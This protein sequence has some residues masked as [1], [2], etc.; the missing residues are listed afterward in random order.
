MKQVN[1]LQSY[2]RQYADSFR[3]AILFFFFFISFF[4]L[5][6]GNVSATA[7]TASA[8]GNW[9]NPA[10][11][12]GSGTPG[13]SDTATIGAG[14]TV[15]VTANVTVSSL[16]LPT[17]SGGNSKVSINSGVTLTVS[18]AV[19]IPRRTGKASNTVAVGSGTL[20][21]GSVA[22]TLSDN[23]RKNLLTI[24]KGTATVIGDITTDGVNK[25]GASVNFTDKGTLNVGGAF[26]TG[27]GTV[28]TKTGSTINYNGSGAQTVKSIA[29]LGNLV[30]SGSGSKSMAAGIVITGNLSIAPGGSS[31]AKAS[32]S[33]T[34]SRAGTLTLA[35]VIQPSGTYGSTTSTAGNKSDTYFAGTGLI[36][37]SSGVADTTH[38][39]ILSVTSSVGNGS[40][41]KDQ[42]INIIVNFSEIVSSTGSVTVNLD[43][44]GTC[45]FSVSLSSTGT[46]NYTVGVGEN[47]SDLNVSSIS[48][49]IADPSGNTMTNFTPATNLAANKAI[50]IDTT[51]PTIS[52]VTSTVANG[53][54]KAGSLIPIRAVFSETVSVTGTPQITLGTGG[55]GRVVNYSTGSGSNTLTFNYT[56]QSGDT[57]SDL[58]TTAI[59]GTFTDA[60]GNVLTNFSP[61]TNLAANKDIVIDT[62]APHVVNVT[63]TNA[64]ANYK[65]GDTIHVQVVFSESVTVSN[66]PHLT[67]LTG[68]P[69]TKAINYTSGSGTATLV[70]DYL[71]GNK[72]F[73]SDLEYASSGSLSASG[74]TTI[75]DAA[76]NA[77]STTLPAPGSGTIGAGSLGV[78]KDITIDATAPTVAITSTSLT[79]TNVPIPVTAKFSEPVIGFTADDVTISNGSVGSFVAV[80]SSTY[81]FSVTPSLQGSVSISILSA[82][83]T[84]IAGN[85]NIASNTLTR[86]YDN[87]A[88]TL[89]LTTTAAGQT[90]ATPLSFTATFS[91]TVTGFVLSDISV[92]GASLGNFQAVSGTVYTFSVSP[93]SNPDILQNTDV[94]ISVDSNKAQDSAGNGNTASNSGS[95]IHIIFDNHNP[96]VALTSG[97]TEYTNASPI[98]MTATFSEPVNGFDISDITVA[99]GTKDNFH[100]NS[101]SAYTFDVAPSSQGVMTV[102]IA[103]GVAQDDASLLNLVSNI[104]STTY[105][106]GPPSVVLS[107]SETSPTN[108]S[109]F[110][111]TATFS[112]D[113]TGFQSSDLS[114]T[115]ATVDNFSGL[116]TT[117]TFDMTPSGGPISISIA[118]GAA[119]DAAGNNN[120]VSNTLSFVY[121]IT[122]PVI[123]EVTPVPALGVDPTPNYTF[124]TTE[125]GAITYGGS[126]GSAT[127]DASSSNNNTITFNEL[128][129]G[130]YDDCSIVVTDAAGNDSL[131]LIVNTFSIS[132]DNPI[133]SEYSPSNNA[134]GV[135][136]TSDLVLTFNKTVVVGTG[137]ITIKTG[138]TV[139]ET[140]AVTSGQVTGSNTNIITI[141]PSVTL[142]NQTPYYV[143][144]DATAFLD[145]FGNSYAGISTSDTWSFTSAD[146][147]AP[148]VSILSPANNATAAPVQ[149]NLV[150]T[151]SENVIVQSGFIT[152]REVDNSIVEDID[153]TGGQVT[154]SG[155]NV[156]NVAPTV[157]LAGSTNYYITVSPTAFAD[158]AGNNYAGIGDSSTWA[159]Q[160]LD[161]TNPFVTA[162]SPIDFATGVGASN[163]LG[164]T[165]NE[166]VFVQSG[167]AISIKNGASTFE[168]ITL[169]DARV[170]GSGTGTITINPTGTL[171]NQTVYYVNVSP[172]ALYDDADNT[173]GNPYDGIAD[174]TT[175]TFTTADVTSPTLSAVSLVSNNTLAPTTLAK[176]GDR[177]TLSFTSSEAISSPAVTFTSGGAS[178]TNPVTISNTSLNNWVASY[179]TSS[180]DTA[181]AIAYSI[182]Y[183]DLAGNAGSPNPSVGGGIT[184]DKTAPTLSGVTLI[185]NN[186]SNT[187]AK[188][189]N[190]ITLSFTTS[191]TISTPSVIFTSGGAPIGGAVTITPSGNNWTATYVTRLSDTEGDVTYAI[192]N[193]H[194]NA[195]NSASPVTS[196]TGSVTFDK[197]APTIISASS[198]KGNGTYTSGESI[199]IIVSFSEAVTSTGNVT[200]TL[201]TGATDRTCTFSVASASSGSCNYTVQA[202]DSTNDLNVSS[203]SGTIADLAGNALTNFTPATNLATNKA[204]VIDTTVPDTTI[205]TIT[206]VTSTKANGSYTTNEVIDIIVS[207]SEAVT[208]TG[209]VTV[210]L[211]TGA[212]DRTCTFSVASASSGSCNYTVQAGDSTNDLNVSS[213][214]GTIADLAGNALTNFTPA[215]NLATNKAIVIDTTT[216]PEILITGIVV[217]GEGSAT[218]LS[219]DGGTLQMLAD[220]LPVDAT[221]TSVTWSVAP[222]TGTGSINGS[223]LL[224]ALTKGTVTVTATANDGSGISDD[225]IITISGQERS[226]A[227][228]TTS[229]H[230]SHHTIIPTITTQEQENPIIP[231]KQE[232]N[233]ILNKTSRCSSDM[234]LTQ[235]LKAGS[236]NGKYSSFTKGIV[237]EVKILQAHL[238]R[239]GFASGKVDGILGPIT[240]G[241]IK[242]MQIYLGTLPDGF[243]GPKTRNLI[244]NSCGAKVLS[245]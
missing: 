42:V 167:E 44:G 201:E 83:A 150:I 211:E 220:I 236:K 76:G 136:A 121:D 114:V 117:Y 110:S 57:S 14:K 20:V 153:V 87:I 12:G 196:G 233:P 152:I 91:E 15:N 170:T 22:F 224:T 65:T 215:T 120:T 39:T 73:T 116:G 245:E 164:M 138:S 174:S 193:F 206:N 219:A 41:K 237:K 140:I 35:N 25:T 119:Q 29:Y 18:G 190:L 28:T 13:S 24:S 128:P 222:G 135:T 213:I 171:A 123:A 31:T 101:R 205:P 89:T 191:E 96:S 61:G 203:I 165:F 212:T 216:T 157:T 200:V 60:A 100:S 97:V 189:G 105:D 129:N 102:S 179:V 238:N 86:S 147:V 79:L 204:I 142:A 53:S 228:E 225:I 77:T 109:L 30:L 88:P 202:G 99:N 10:T 239:L 240:D 107:T 36:T 158:A 5:K 122:A 21:A 175:W 108:A 184:F 62:L 168:S 210:T 115:N 227:S 183:H 43:T 63:S 78:N 163:N 144:V 126:C 59:S 34:T 231:D 185:S 111:V 197:T 51:L 58:T 198:N 156:I 173:I 84:D 80:S 182:N 94:N 17:G 124:S 92:S 242:R 134:T 176:A 226:S 103:A 49:T 54:Y 137:N 130:I 209:N 23:M 218:T 93:V 26:L 112:E 82:V 32:L 56:V 7:F 69:V 132:N 8:N 146:T 55:G 1:S 232:K 9:N 85:E 230:H 68:S 229:V 166:N 221:N 151:F 98:S 235:N 133:V 81:T 11:W 64:N 234:I 172:D 95:P 46:C 149:S 186:S 160:T 67:L 40:Y 243:V 47:S 143:L 169:P 162:F 161:T 106:T 48:G 139:V 159:F 27:G 45:S 72:N 154:G 71:V 244:N 70:F 127:S 131:P 241:A 74:S 104:F 66:T 217:K 50:V 194:D 52:S 38:P 214:S 192:D 187:H 195:N 118:G 199:D 223:G 90:S 155:T 113:V 180:S 177:V 181:G 141:N 6:P 188:V 3:F 145:I 4:L 33:G 178:V 75:A 125:N 2:N 207:F 208:S 19:T 37:I 16:S 148:T